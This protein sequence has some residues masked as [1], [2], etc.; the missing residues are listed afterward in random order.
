M[1]KLTQHLQQR[2]SPILPMILAGIPVW[3]IRSR[4]AGQPVV[5]SFAGEEFIITR[6]A[7]EIVATAPT[8]GPICAGLAEEV[9][10]GISPFERA[11]ARAAAE[12]D[13]LDACT[14][15]EPVM[16][17]QGLDGD[18]AEF[19]Q[20]SYSLAELAAGEV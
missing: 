16:I 17:W 12:G 10:V 6:I 3:P 1:V 9:V 13:R 14:D 8:V 7:V 18:R 11:I 19:R 4:C 15:S 2:L 20:M 5:R